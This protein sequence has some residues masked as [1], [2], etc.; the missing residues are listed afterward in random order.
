MHLIFVLKMAA[1]CYSEYVIGL[2]SKNLP[3]FDLLD[4]FFC[5]SG[6]GGG[7]PDC[8]N[9]LLPTIKELNSWNLMTQQLMMTPV[10][11][12]LIY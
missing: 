11:R 8:V 10:L 7:S 5:S 6:G 3:I 9:R 12:N 4:L 1:I 2:A